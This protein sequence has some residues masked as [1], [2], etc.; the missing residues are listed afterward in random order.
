[1]PS[2]VTLPLVPVDMVAVASSRTIT[3]SDLLPI[4]GASISTSR[5]RRMK[6][7]FT[8]SLATIA[9]EAAAPP[10]SMTRMAPSLVRIACVSRITLPPLPPLFDSSIRPLLSRLPPT[11]RWALPTPRPWLGSMFK[12]PFWVKLAIVLASATLLSPE[13]PTVSSASLVTG[14]F[15]ASAESTSSCS[16]FSVRS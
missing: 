4:S 3:P 8:I 10:S 7:L 13:P 5:L 15:K 14:R 2:L 11:C 9:T 12:R 1:M 6:P 16:C